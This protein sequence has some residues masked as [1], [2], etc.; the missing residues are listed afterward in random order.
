MNAEKNYYDPVF[1]EED[2][3][4]SAPIPLYQNSNI[5]LFSKHSLIC[6]TDKDLKGFEITFS[7]P[8]AKSHDISVETEKLSARR[9][10]ASLFLD[11]IF[12]N[13]SEPIEID[14]VAT[15]SGQPPR[16][17]STKIL[18]TSANDFPVAPDFDNAMYTGG[19][20]DNLEL[21]GLEAI[22]INHY[23]EQE[24][25]IEKTGEHADLFNIK[26]NDSKITVTLAKE[27]T[28]E[29]VIG[30][31]FLSFE[32]KASRSDL[33]AVS[34]AGVVVS[35]PVKTLISK[36]GEQLYNGRID[37][38]NSLI[39]DS[40]ALQTEEVGSVVFAL[41]RADSKYFDIHF[42]SDAHEVSLTLRNTDESWRKERFL[43]VQVLAKIEDRVLATTEV[44]VE[45]FEEGKLCLIPLIGLVLFSS[46]YSIR[47]CSGVA[48]LFV[49]S[50]RYTFAHDKLSLA[51]APIMSIAV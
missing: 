18:I 49:G 28:E 11:K 10:C 33:Q 38:P 51:A 27:L 37:P 4:I 32:F 3:D 13:I 35:V 19:L 47:Y 25:N 23:D 2:N 40:I 17:T 24:V 34:N 9:F 43:E 22:T 50:A 1:E 31:S 36:F 48:K 29:E 46:S 20:D 7:S 41:D 26:I 15:D 16:S 44:V 45:V 42:N 5:S 6:A 8:N 21:V 14:L 30:R 39:L 12:L